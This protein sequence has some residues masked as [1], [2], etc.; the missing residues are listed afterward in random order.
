MNHRAMDLL[1]AATALEHD[2]VLVT[3]NTRHYADVADLRLHQPVGGPSA[4][5]G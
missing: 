4:G 5:D 3:R 2:L 1:I